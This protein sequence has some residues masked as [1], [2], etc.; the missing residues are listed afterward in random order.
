MVCCYL[1]VGPEVQTDRII[2]ACWRQG[3]KV[4]VPAFKSDTHSYELAG[5]EEGAATVAGPMGISEPATR[6]WVSI[7][8]VDLMI[9]PGTAFDRHGGRLGRG[10]GH[11]DAI[12]R[13]KT[14]R[15]PFSIGLA[16]EL[17]LL[18]R[19]PVNDQDVKV[20]AVVTETKTIRT[21]EHKSE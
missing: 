21:L 12:M 13:R 5:W 20:D 7:D 3:K 17:Q 6:T 19:V 2:E 1:A 8:S 9:V 16:F 15:S 4:C 18:E 10:G 14:G 11:Y